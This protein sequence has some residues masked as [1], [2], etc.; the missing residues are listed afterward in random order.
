MINA[1]NILNNLEGDLYSAI[2]RRQK[3]IENIANINSDNFVKSFP[4]ELS[5][6][7]LSVQRKTALDEELRNLQTVRIEGLMRLWSLRY[8]DMRR[9]VTLGKG[10]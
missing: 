4:K 5:A 10:G 2:E 1:A 9:I 8:Q 7:E 3:A 6:A